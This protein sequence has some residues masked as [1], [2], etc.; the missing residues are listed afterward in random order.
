MTEVSFHLTDG[1]AQTVPVA[2]NAF[3]LVSKAPADRIGEAGPA[4]SV[5]EALPATSLTNG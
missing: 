4:G 5:T 3:K 1:T 2:N